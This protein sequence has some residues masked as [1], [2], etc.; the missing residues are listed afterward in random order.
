[1]LPG[2]RWATLLRTTAAPT[3]CPASIPKP[4]RL[5]TFQR[6]QLL[7]TAPSYPVNFSSLQRQPTPLHIQ[8]A[9]SQCLPTHH[10]GPSAYQ[11]HG[12]SPKEDKEAGRDTL[13]ATQDAPTLIAE[14]VLAQQLHQRGEDEETRRDGVH[15]PDKNK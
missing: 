2:T 10:L 7:R 9:S 8:L 11:T 12:K 6:S 3:P 4:D 14:E 13:L 15:G 1:M 5:A